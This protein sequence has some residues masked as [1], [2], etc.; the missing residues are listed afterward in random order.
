MSQAALPQATRP[1]L[2]VG[3]I[4]R[5]IAL[6][7]GALAVFAGGVA[8]GLRGD[9]VTILGLGVLT[10]AVAAVPI[11]VDGF[12]PP[13]KRSLL[14]TFLSAMYVVYFVVPA[15]ADYLLLDD[16][17]TSSMV[18]H[19]HVSSRDIIRGQ[20]VALIG[21]VAMI[22]GFASPIGRYLT[23]WLP[24]PRREWSHEATLVV[25]LVMIPM[26]WSVLLAA[27]LG[28]LPKRFGSGVIGQL[29][30]GAYYGIALLAI[31]YL[32]YRSRA[33]LLLLLLLIP[34]TVVFGFFTSSKRMMLMPIALVA[35]AQILVSRRIRAFWIVGLVVV[36]TLIY[37]VIQ[38]YRD[39]LFS[40]NLGALDVIRSPGYAF[41]LMSGFLAR[42]DV[43][44]YLLSGLE[45]T[46]V[47]FNALGILS[48]I[49]RDT[50]VLVPFQGGWSL[51]LIVIAY[52]PR[53]FW[54]GKPSTTIGQW[55]TDHFGSGPIIVSDTGPSWVGE[56]YFNFG[57]S[58]VILGMVFLGIWFRVIQGMLLGRDAIIPALLAGVMAMPVAIRFEGGVI[59]PI[60]G[61]F[62]SF[63][64]VFLAHFF[65]R[66]FSRPPA[67]PPGGR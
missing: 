52:V 1:G 34:P 51:G 30:L 15:F 54:P 35:M 10:A 23:A 11:V 3:P 6:P 31:S 66:L 7:F 32:R 53:V 17:M 33:A 44:D 27:Q 5:A 48:A 41:S 64:P 46:G 38:L 24:H 8:A 21:L 59:A 36:L 65:V 22:A 56:F 45:A 60:N 4:L 63:I 40:N 29:G 61:V 37:P 2:P 47:R 50:G 19:V 14:L 39:Y 13:E 58:G 67:A 62:Y 49:V 42:A 18:R 9:D 20:G 28:V 57:Y 55:V 26:G 16:R 25:A 43:G 12:R